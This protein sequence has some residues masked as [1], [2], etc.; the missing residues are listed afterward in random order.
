LLVGEDAVKCEV[1]N[2]FATAAILQIS[3]RKEGAKLVLS[4]KIKPP[5]ALL[6]MFRAKKWAIMLR[7]TE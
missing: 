5:D 3:I 4:S 2:L 6:D 7:L 1:D